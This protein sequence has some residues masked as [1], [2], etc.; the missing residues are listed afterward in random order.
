LLEY[1]VKTYTL[2]GEVVL[3]NCM[4]S[5]STGI[6]CVNTGRQFIGMEKDETYFEL[7]K[8]RILSHGSP[9]G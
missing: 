9:N 4:G 3:D 8:E 2:E 7:A 6:A 5:G 1:L